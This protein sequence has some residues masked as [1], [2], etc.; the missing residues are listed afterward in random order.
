[1][2]QVQQSASMST[3]IPGHV[4]E[5]YSQRHKHQGLMFHTASYLTHQLEAHPF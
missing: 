5:I 1:M 4:L 3:G 2:E